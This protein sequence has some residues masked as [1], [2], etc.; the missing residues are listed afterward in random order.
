MKEKKKR[1]IGKGPACLAGSWRWGEV[2]ALRKTPS[3]WGNLLGPFGGLKGNAVNGMWKAGQSKDCVHGLGHSPA[4]PRLSHVSSLMEGDWVLEN[5]IGSAD[6][7]RGQLLCV[8]R[9]SAGTG[10]RSST[11]GEVCGRCLEHHRAKASLLSGMQGLEPPL[12][13]PFP[14]SGFCLYRH[15]EGHSSEQCH[16]PLKPRPLPM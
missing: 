6:P 8:K 13:P 2:P 3:Q 5:G 4:H 7:G 1:G 14:P 16:P 10:V 9:Q 12:Q 15:W 11:T